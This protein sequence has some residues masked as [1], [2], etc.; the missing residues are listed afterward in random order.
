L[1][2]KEVLIQS[3]MVIALDISCIKKLSIK[4][5]KSIP[6]ERA[7]KDIVARAR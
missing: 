2:D 3:L 5:H 4:V 7:M 6:T 1:A